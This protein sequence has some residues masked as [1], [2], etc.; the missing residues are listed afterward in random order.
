MSK[1]CL[2]TFAFTGEIMTEIS[3]GPLPDIQPQH[4]T[5]NPV[6]AQTCDLLLNITFIQSSTVQ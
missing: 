6:P 2:Y 1:I 3:P 5:I 4:W